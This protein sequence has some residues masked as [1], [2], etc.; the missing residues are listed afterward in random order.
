MALS[1][2]DKKSVGELIV[3]ECTNAESIAENLFHAIE[4]GS[5]IRVLTVIAACTSDPSLKSGDKNETFVY[6]KRADSFK[7]SL[8]QVVNA[9]C[10]AF[11]TAGNSMERIHL[12]LRGMPDQ[13]NDI[14]ETINEL[15]KSDSQEIIDNALKTI[16]HV[17]ET[18][19]TEA[20]Q[21]DDEFVK[22]L[23][24]IKELLECTIATKGRSERKETAAKLELKEH[25]RLEKQK[26]ALLEELKIQYEE[27]QEIARE[28][29]EEYKLR[30]SQS[31]NFTE[32]VGIMLLDNITSLVDSVGKTAVNV[33]A[34]LEKLPPNLATALQ[35]EFNPSKAFLKKDEFMG[36]AMENVLMQLMEDIV[37]QTADELFEQAEEHI[38]NLKCANSMI[39]PSAMGKILHKI[40]TNLVE[41]LESISKKEPTYEEKF[42]TAKS[43]V[44]IILK[45]CAKAQDMEDANVEEMKQLKNLTSEERMTLMTTRLEN[46]KIS[47][48]NSAAQ[49]K[50]QNE[51][52]KEKAAAEAELVD[53]ISKM[54]AL[55]MEEINLEEVLKYLKLG[56]QQL[57]KVQ[58]AWRNIVAFFD[59]IK[60]TVDG[61]LV[62][63]VQQVINSVETIRKRNENPS[64]TA[65]CILFREVAKASVVSYI[66][67]QTAAIYKQISKGHVMPL[68]D[69][70]VEMFGLSIEEALSQQYNMSSNYHKVKD[71]VQ[72][73][74]NAHK[75]NL[76]L[77]VYAELGKQGF[78]VKRA[79]EDKKI[80]FNF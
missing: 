74:I 58:N 7:A 29:M 69:E 66:L 76:S 45:A 11:R 19:A 26:K 8:Y 16:S 55:E 80:N 57:T 54:E 46:L 62:N 10:E 20:K 65:H 64:N 14:L 3:E 15:D 47:R 63:H 39:N 31:T 6:L 73:A 34:A 35:N 32:L 37:K 70:S 27:Q 23:N 75:D 13:M 38:K 22:A 51:L 42:Q 4:A 9:M 79:V 59:H 40:S 1:K 36:Q 60:N 53:I 28:A 41:A 61:T 5:M 72:L 30:M 25:H 52:R 56:I 48:E 24:I 2:H 50:L 18:C 12:S 77:K 17:A 49:R 67:M 43:E 44:E 21:A 68:I 33:S 71:C 78:D